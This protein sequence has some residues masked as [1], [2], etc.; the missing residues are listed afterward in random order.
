MHFHSFEHLRMRTH[1]DFFLGTC[2]LLFSFMQSSVHSTFRLH[3]HFLRVYVS[4]RLRLRKGSESCIGGSALESLARSCVGYI[5]SGLQC[6]I[7]P[8]IG[9]LGYIGTI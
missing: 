2:P 1:I 4:A 5:L 3:L 8:M 6:Y 7:L 9:L